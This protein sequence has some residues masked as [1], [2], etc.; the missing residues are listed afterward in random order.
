MTD[1]SDDMR[2]FKSITDVFVKFVSVI[3]MLLVAGIV[4]MMLTEL[5]ARNFFNKSFRFSTELCG[6]LFMWMAFL[7]VI[8]LYD[9]S[10]LVTLDILYT[11][12][13]A[14][15]QTVMWFINKIFSLGLGAVMIV[16]YCGM[17]KINSTSYFSTM[18]F[19]SKAWH[20]LPM[21]IA[22]GFIVVKSIQQLLERLIAKDNAQKQGG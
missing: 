1:R 15:V 7:G 16:A 14:K 9:R 2:L 13:P 6:F 12:M 17:Y 3:L 21:A 19:L 11:R 22:G 5:C 10:G 20:F 8:V 18:Q 4:A